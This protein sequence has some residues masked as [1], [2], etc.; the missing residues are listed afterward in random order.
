VRASEGGVTA[1]I[2]SMDSLFKDMYPRAGDRIKQ[3]VV[4]QRREYDWERETCPR[5]SVPEHEDNTG[6]VCRNSNDKVPWTYLNHDCCHDCGDYLEDLRETPSVQAWLDEK[7]KRPPIEQD[8][9]KY[10]DEIAE[11]VM[12]QDH[13]ILRAMI[14]KAGPFDE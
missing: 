12:M 14:P 8:R 4:D 6:A 1:T 2:T 10:S 7:A 3:W 9:T 13:P 11:D 5:F